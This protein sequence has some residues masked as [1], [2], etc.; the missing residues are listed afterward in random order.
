MYLRAYIT[1]YPR[2]ITGLVLLDASTPE[3][4]DR[5]PAEINALQRKFVARLDW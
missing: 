3:Q 1:K 5:L 4:V 2:G